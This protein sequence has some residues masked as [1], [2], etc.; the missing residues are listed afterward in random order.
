MMKKWLVEVVLWSVL[1]GKVGAVDKVIYRFDAS[2]LS[3]NQRNFLATFQGVINRNGPKLYLHYWAIDD[4]WIEKMRGGGYFLEGYEVRRLNNFDELLGQFGNRL[5]GWVIWDPK[6]PATLNLANSIGGAE[7]YPI[8]MATDRN[9][10]EDSFYRQMINKIS[11]LTVIDLRDRFTGVGKL[12]NGDFTGTGVLDS[13]GS[14]KNDVYRWG[15][16]YLIKTGKVDPAVLGFMADAYDYENSPYETGN[17]SAGYT[18]GRDW[19]T[20]RKA[21]LFDLDMWN[22]TDQR[23]PV[24]DPGHP[25]E[26]Y[27]TRDLIFR[28]VKAKLNGGLFVVYGYEPY[29][30][31]YYQAHCPEAMYPCDGAVEWE[32]VKNI[33]EHG[34]Y[35]LAGGAERNKSVHMHQSELEGLVQNLRPQPREVENKTYLMF[36]NGDWDGTYSPNEGAWLWFD[37]QESRN[38]AAI[39]DLPPL[40]WSFNTLVAEHYPDFYK[41][42]YNTKG[43]RDYFVASAGGGAYVLPNYLPEADLKQYAEKIQKVAGKIDYSVSPFNIDKFSPSDLVK[44]Y[45]LMFSGDGYGY[46]HVEFDI[47]GKDYWPPK[48]DWEVSPHN[49]GVMPVGQQINVW[50]GEAA[51][52]WWKCGGREYPSVFEGVTKGSDNGC[53]RSSD[54][55]RGGAAEDLIYKIENIYRENAKDLGRRPNFVSIRLGM[56]TPRWAGALVRR[57]KELKPEYNF[58]AVDPFTFGYLMRK[59]MGGENVKR[60]SW[61]EN[62]LPRMI[63]KGRDF[64]VRLKIRNDGW[65]SWKS[66]RTDS[67]TYYAPVVFIQKKNGEKAGEWWGSLGADTV[68]PGEMTETV[69]RVRAPEV[70]GEYEIKLDMVHN[71]VGWFSDAGDVPW[72]KKVVVTEGSCQERLMEGDVNLDSVVDLADFIVWKNAFLTRG[73]GTADLNC[74]GGID[75]SDFII[76]KQGFIKNSQ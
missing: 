40:A 9:G 4:T 52:D 76:W 47:G 71:Q 62:N 21:F 6:V 42:Y 69:V 17:G 58:E 55:P 39:E 72:Y 49:Y 64:E 5:R 3:Y 51:A 38:R 68:G 14:R 24:D 45:Y 12:P 54:Y 25:G 36:F 60:A 63:Q 33:S 10:A 2:N 46:N 27:R 50:N 11:G 67:Q 19:L 32:N 31:K 22:E 18:G 44:R 23:W 41:Y 29:R 1:A 16:E 30:Q 53:V 56:I 75:I 28:T 48:G 35:Q 73:S 20:A 70:A 15:V 34:G 59:S 43:P 66:S 74:D 37:T 13:S 61:L 57:L 7:G 65:E 26:D 8:I